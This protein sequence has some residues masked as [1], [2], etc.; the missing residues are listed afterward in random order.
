[1]E[2]KYPKNPYKNIVND[3]IHETYLI[4][5]YKATYE[6]SFAPINMENLLKNSDCEACNIQSC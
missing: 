4:T 6:A 5:S 1:M 2:S 3:F